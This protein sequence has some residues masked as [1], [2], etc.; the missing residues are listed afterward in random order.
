MFINLGTSILLTI[1][2]TVPSYKRYERQNKKLY[3][4]GTEVGLKGITSRNDQERWCNINRRRRH[5]GSRPVHL[6]GSVL[7]KT[8]RAEKDLKFWISQGRQAFTMLKPIWNPTTE[9]RI[10]ITT[11]KSVP[12]YRSETWR[13]STV[14]KH[15]IQF[16]LIPLPYMWN[17]VTSNH[18]QQPVYPDKLNKT[19]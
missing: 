3:E 18:N 10:F 2:T 4:K 15:K 17:K 16:L 9:N 12:L 14:F 7:N 11:V 6:S 1:C 13:L 8:S 19:Q 5:K